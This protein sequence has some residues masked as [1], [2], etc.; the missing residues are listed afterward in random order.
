M[1][2]L[3]SVLILAASMLTGCAAMSTSTIDDGLFESTVD[4]L[5]STESKL[6]RKGTILGEDE[7]FGASKTYVQYG[8]NSNNQYV[9][10]FATAIKGNI[11]NLVYERAAVEGKEAATI[12]VST[13][14]A[15]I[16]AGEEIW[17][18]NGTDIT[19]NSECKGNYYWACY[20]IGFNLDSPHY[21]TDFDVKLKVNN[22]E[23]SSKVASLASLCKGTTYKFEAEAA[24]L[25]TTITSLGSGFETGFT[26]ESSN[27]SGTGYIYKIDKE[28]EATF[29]Y[30]IHSSHVAK[31]KL[32]ITI[33]R[34]GKD[35]QLKDLFAVSVNGNGY[36]FEDYTIT[37][38]VLSGNA[39]YTD[40]VTLDVCDIDLN[41]GNN[42][43]V[44]SKTAT[45]RNF[46]YISL[47]SL[48]TLQLQSEVET[49][50]NY[51][52]KVITEPTMETEGL[53]H[54]YCS[55]CHDRKEEFV[56]PV[57]SESNGY[58]IT[59]TEEETIYTLINGGHEFK[60]TVSKEKTYE[61]LVAN[62]NPF[63]TENG[64]SADG[65]SVTNSA[66]NG[67]Y[68]QKNTGKTFTTTINIAE[69]A[70]IE[71]V[72]K[73]TTT[74]NR[75][76]NS[77]TVNSIKLNNSEEGVTVIDSSATGEGWNANTKMVDLTVASLALKAGTHVISF[78]RDASTA[79]E[80]N[81]N[82]AGLIFKSFTPVYLGVGA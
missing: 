63:A 1:K 75:V 24:R 64:G 20:T 15:G 42:E 26:F 37:A 80:N 68:Y 78:T 67:M 55:I 6:I 60:F 38:S 49:G 39:K 53:A 65:L 19:T 29:S 14:Y 9:M 34:G 40:W 59:D 31:A 66:T 16:K 77:N 12:E 56:L 62:N 7:T 54:S 33:A 13:V 22:E 17:Y 2:K 58:V 72:I 61:F 47:E 11:E 71:L 76:I 21:Y 3:Y 70:T 36:D 48:A 18:Y 44:L 46:D 27:P 10:R 5:G 79:N 45:G 52:W 8:V 82:I 69:D 41:E 50:H 73:I 30:D 81:Y 43:V 23:V 32:S 74:A 35:V 4:A 51:E 57:L 28:G 25:E